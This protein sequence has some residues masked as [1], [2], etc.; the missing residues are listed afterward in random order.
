MKKK[1]LEDSFGLTTMPDDTLFIP[2]D[3]NEDY[4]SREIV[5]QSSQSVARTSVRYL[6]E[7]GMIYVPT[8]DEIEM[9]LPLRSAPIEAYVTAQCVKLKPLTTRPNFD[10]HDEIAKVLDQ[11]R[12]LEF[13]KSKHDLCQFLQNRVKMPG[14]KSQSHT[15]WNVSS[16]DEILDTLETVKT[17]TWDAKIHRAYGQ[18]MLFSSVNIQVEIGHKSTVTGRMF[19]HTAIL[20]ELARKK[21]GCVSKDEVD[22]MISSYKDEYYAGK[23]W[24][25]VMDWFS[26]S[27]IVLVFV[28]S[29]KELLL[30]RSRS[31]QR[32][33]LF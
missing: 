11:S 26:G 19:D 9:G 30:I 18:T 22:H 23:K 3:D 29:G 15:T 33:L 27:G 31:C 25:A 28:T 8:D 5:P 14:R 4:A 10:V 24:L 6:Q 20:E 21:A 13:Y 16:P 2:K 12:S 17:N 32:V 1:R 7:G